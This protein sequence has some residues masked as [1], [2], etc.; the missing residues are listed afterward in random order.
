MV[1]NT[2][3]CSNLKE[4]KTVAA[5][6]IRK[7]AQYQKIPERFLAFPLPLKHRENLT[8]SKNAKGDLLGFFIVPFVAE[9]LNSLRVDPSTTT[10]FFFKNSHIAGKT[11]KT[12]LSELS[13]NEKTFKT[14]GSRR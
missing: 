4:G 3:C 12:Q 1:A 10:R 13:N 9:S 5:K 8:G 6:N 14:Y 11:N 2:R 7:V